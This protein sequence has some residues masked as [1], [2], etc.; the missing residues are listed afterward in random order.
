MSAK[1]LVL[2]NC[3]NFDL[4]SLN[5]LLEGD[6]SKLR[7]IEICTNGLLFSTSRPRVKPMKDS[8]QVNETFRG[9][10]PCEVMLC[11]QMVTA[12]DNTSK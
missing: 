11:A 4:V 3:S 5:N 1:N 9:S 12:P 6:M 2:T 7:Y 10:R 8:S